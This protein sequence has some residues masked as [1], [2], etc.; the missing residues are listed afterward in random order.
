MSIE[1]RGEA[2]QENKS[3]IIPNYLLTC[4]KLHGQASRKEKA[5]K[6]DE[7]LPTVR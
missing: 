6:L 2:E 4:Y 3:Y 7:Q 5:A 1:K